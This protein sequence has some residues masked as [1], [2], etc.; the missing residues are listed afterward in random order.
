MVTKIL[1]IDLRALQLK[2]CLEKIYSMNPYIRKEK[3]IS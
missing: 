2:G 1:D 3:S